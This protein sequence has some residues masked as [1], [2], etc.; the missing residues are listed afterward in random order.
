MRS[1]SPRGRARSLDKPP[2]PADIAPL[3]L[4]PALQILSV[5]SALA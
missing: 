2:D 4:W 3:A 5:S 1:Q